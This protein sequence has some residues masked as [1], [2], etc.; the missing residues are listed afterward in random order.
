M[1]WFAWAPIRSRELMATAK[2]LTGVYRG[3]ELSPETAVWPGECKL[4]AGRHA[5]KRLI[6]HIRSDAYDAN[7]RFRSLRL[8]GIARMS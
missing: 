5:R 6:F 8:C 7:E 4:I 2:H 1:D 3:T